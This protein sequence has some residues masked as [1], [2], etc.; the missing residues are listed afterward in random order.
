MASGGRD[1]T[2]LRGEQIVIDLRGDEPVLELEAHEVPFLDLRAQ[3]ADLEKEII[4]RWTHLLRTGAFIGGDTVRTFEESLATYLG[5][6]YAVG[7]ANGTD[8]IMLA[9][10]ALGIQPGD[11]VIAPAN[12]FFATIEAIVH[13]GGTPVLVDVDEDTALIDPGATREA[14]TARTRFIMPVHLYGQ[15][16]DMDALMQIA[17]DHELLVVEDN[18]QAIGARYK[19]RRTGT[20]GHAA[21]VSFYPGKNLGATGDGGAVTTND[22]DVAAQVR[23]LANHGQRSKYDHVAVG[24]NSRLDALHAAALS[25]KLSHLDSWNARRRYV[26]DRY[27]VLV[28]DPHIAHPAVADDRTHVF[29]LYV[30]RFTNREWTRA[31]LERRGIATG[32][33]YP[34]PI[35]LT[36][37][38]NHLGDPGAFPV[39]ER[40]ARE[41]LSLP[42]FPEM[43]DAQITAVAGAVSESLEEPHV[44]ARDTA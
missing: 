1:V 6:D 32:L 12:T 5:A 22:A 24:Y 42:M 9:L 2:H 11:E 18:A 4:E 36:A 27:R 19:G 23:I 10:K 25:I 3:H 20:I 16:A 43:S 13:A 37:P 44:L 29:H 17:A 28:D 40:W 41:G 30:A 15:P 14:I 7:V 31:E 35:H 26:A 8:A 34:T 39:A 33:H 21:A 38:F